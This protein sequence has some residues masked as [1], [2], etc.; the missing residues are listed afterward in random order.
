MSRGHIRRNEYYTTAVGLIKEAGL[1]WREELGA[2]HGKIFV[3][4][5]GVEHMLTITGSPGDVR[6]IRNFRADVKRSIRQWKAEAAT[7]A[8][9]AAP[10]QLPTLEKE[11]NVDTTFEIALHE[12]DGEPRTLDVDLGA[13]LGFADPRKIRQLIERNAENLSSFSV[14]HA[15]SETSSKG[16][17]PARVHYLTEEQ[18]LY[19]AAVS[20]APRAHDVRVMLIKVFVAWRRGQLQVPTELTRVFGIVKQMNHKI[21]ETEKAIE[22]I[23]KFLTSPGGSLVPSF[24]M[25]G[26]VTAL[27][28][29]TL[30]GIKADQ[31]VK[32]TSAAVTLRMKDFCLINGFTSMKTPVAIDTSARWRFQREA[33]Q[34]WLFG[35]HGGAEFIRSHVRARRGDATPDMFAVIKGGKR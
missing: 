12:I 18:A 20:D 27:D 3:D 35:K 10:A 30:A 26:S 13:K 32:G 9:S 16:G 23:Q 33:A 15:V 19:I 25:S 2:K 4:V 6:G 22:E 1:R 34:Q 8:G 28:I 11:T 17:R 5:D 29:I 7:F 31:R 21:T 24:D 14:L